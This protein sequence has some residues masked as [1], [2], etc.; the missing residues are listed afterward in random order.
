MHYL[1]IFRGLIVHFINR[2]NKSISCEMP[3][4]FL[5]FNSSVALADL[6]IFDFGLNALV[7]RADDL[8][9][10]VELFDPVS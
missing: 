7:S 8:A 9:L 1:N 4:W 5:M 3:S 10:A 2:K 6:V